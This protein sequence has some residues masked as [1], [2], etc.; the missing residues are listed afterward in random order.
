MHPVIY[1]IIFFSALGGIGM[2]IANR[3]VEVTARRQRWIKYISYIL[4]TGTIITGIFFHFFFWLAWIIILA[5]LV[6]LSKVNI[7]APV[8]RSTEILS[9]MIFLPVAAGFIFFAGAFND[10][11]LLF[12]YFQVLVFDG[13]CQITGQ[14]F[15]KHPLA[16]RISPSKTWEGLAGGWLCCIVAAYMA[17]GW[18]Q[19]GFGTKYFGLLSGVFTG[20]TCFCGDLLASYYKRKAQ[21][22]DYSNWLPGQGGFLDRFDSLLLTGAVYYLLYIVIF[23]EGFSEFINQK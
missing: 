15:G 23:N 6:E 19:G 1:Y 3:K 2:G 9:Y 14:L 13:F 12:I 11:F 8:K 20:L 22:K 17:T 4:I 18:L 5:S 21:V 10:S 7:S 16:P